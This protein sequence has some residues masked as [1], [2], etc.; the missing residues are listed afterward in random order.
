MY[1]PQEPK[2]PSGCMQALVITRVVF[3]LLAVPVAII[4][5]AMFTLAM[6]FYLFTVNPLLA[7][8]P[9]VLGV[10][11]VVVLFRI[12]QARIAKESLPSDDC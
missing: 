10:V 8:I 3:G 2:E 12:E 9:L 1:Y 5:G 7:L 4:G 6:T 11:G